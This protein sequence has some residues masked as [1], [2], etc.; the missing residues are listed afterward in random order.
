MHKCTFLPTCN[1][2]G[3]PNLQASYPKHSV[4]GAQ[5][6][7]NT[8][9]VTEIQGGSRT[10]EAPSMIPIIGLQLLHALCHLH[11][12]PHFPF[13]AAVPR[14]PK[15]SSSAPGEMKVS[16]KD[17]PSSGQY[18]AGTGPFFPAASPHCIQPGP[19][20]CAVARLASALCQVNPGRSRGCQEHGVLRQQW[21]GPW[22][23]APGWMGVAG[24]CVH[25][26]AAWQL[27][28]EP[29]DRSSYRH[30]MALRA[31]ANRPARLGDQ[32]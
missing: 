18:S 17:E 7:Q 3:S 11:S 12:S 29:P 30:E 25:G 8:E 32:N 15:S 22:V 14:T 31:D 4:Q 23:W 6:P 16:G 5:L 1:P 19:N 21:T 26:Q 20:T 13:S 9:R 2:A 24:A 10:F 28:H 27:Q